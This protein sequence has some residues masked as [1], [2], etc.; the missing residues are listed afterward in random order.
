MA[1]I[2]NRS[3]NN[4]YLS[5]ASN[6]DRF[7][8]LPPGNYIVQKSLV[9]FYLEKVDSFDAP[10]RIYGDAEKIARRLLR[11]YV[12]RTN[13]TGVLLAGEKGSGKTLT[14]KL[15]SILAAGE[16][17][18]TI[19]INAPWCGADFNQFLQEITQPCIV[20]FD[21]FE[22][23]YPKEQ[24]EAL[25]TLLDG[26][27]PTKKL[28][29]FTVNDKF[30]IDVNMTN[31]PGR[32]FYSIDYEGLEYGFIRDYCGDNLNDKQYV[33]AVAKCST[34]FY[35]FNFDMLKAIIEEMNRYGESPLEAMKYLNAKPESQGSHTYDVVLTI[36]GKAVPEAEFFDREFHGN[37]LLSNRLCFTVY[38]SVREDGEPGD[39]THVFTP[40]HIHSIDG[41]KGVYIYRKGDV[42]AVLSREKEEK[43]SLADGYSRVVS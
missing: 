43:F 11:T 2:F 37:P 15:T 28:F 13:S 3:G 25:L 34:L 39:I 38:P 40:A 33:E 9:G 26:V 31:R 41:E 17:T 19:L 16:G 7:E 27:F 4:Y 23:V 32:I 8:K 1:M 36:G 24:Q 14:G 10:T 6:S 30:K 20:F 12:S 42:Q 35:R 22:K 21:E 29:I 18:P 5:D